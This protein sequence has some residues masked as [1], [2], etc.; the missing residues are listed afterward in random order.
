MKKNERT[1]KRTNVK[2]HPHTC[3]QVDRKW[4]NDNI[5]PYE[6]T[7]IEN[8]SKND[9]DLID[10]AFKVNNFVLKQ[11]DFVKII[12]TYEPKSLQIKNILKSINLTAD[13]CLFIDDNELEIEEVKNSSSEITCEKFP[14]NINDLPAFIENLRNYFDFDNITLED[15]NRTNLYKSKIDSLSVLKGKHGCI[16]DYLKSL[17]Q[18]LN[19]RK[20]DPRNI[21]RAIQL[22]NKTN[23]FNLNGIRRSKEE[24]LKMINEEYNIYIGELLDKNGSQGEIVVILVQNTGLI[25]SFVMSCRVFQR[26]IEYAILYGLKDLSYKQLNFEYLPTKRNSP[27]LKFAEE[28]SNLKKNNNFLI[29]LTELKSNAQQIKNVIDINII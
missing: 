24:I 28:I 21:D 15:K 13:A 1:N 10:E 7:E 3:K 17:K 9:L 23:Q 19:I 4:S 12:G 26:K 2:K 18:I 27:F 25:S 14:E 6:W 11:E 29:N 5:L 16:D 22:I 8:V 20:G